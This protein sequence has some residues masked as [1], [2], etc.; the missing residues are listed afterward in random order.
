MAGL[1]QHV[2]LGLEGSLQHAHQHAALSCQIAADLLLEC[3]VE[4]VAASNTHCQSKC[5]LL[6]FACGILEHCVGTVDAASLQEVC[7]HCQAG[8]LWRNQDH[9]DVLWWNNPCLIVIDHAKAVREVQRLARG[10]I[11]LDLGPNVLLTSIRNQKLN[12]S[13]LVGR[14]LH[15]K[16]V[17]ALNPAILHGGIPALALLHANADFETVVAQIQGLATTLGTIPQHGRCLTRH[18]LETFGDR[19][20][21]ALNDLFLHALDIQNSERTSSAS[22]CGCRNLTSS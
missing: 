6:G 21:R 16:Q 18:N 12:D 5:S 9:V 7:P 13:G 10:Q 14:L 15:G 2:I 20:V 22:E 3:G 4:H 11:R 8:T 19:V 1:T 17:F